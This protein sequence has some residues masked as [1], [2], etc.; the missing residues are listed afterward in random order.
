MANPFVFGYADTAE[1]TSIIP[2]NRLGASR[3]GP[4]HEWPGYTIAPPLLSAFQSC[5]L[6]AVH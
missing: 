5:K 6:I 3:A 1:L 2:L 4:G